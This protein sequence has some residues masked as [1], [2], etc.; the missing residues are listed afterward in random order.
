VFEEEWSGVR[1]HP[2]A[3]TAGALEAPAPTGLRQQRGRLALT[4][5]ENP[6]TAHS[7][8][9]GIYD[10]VLCGHSPFLLESCVWQ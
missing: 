9:V 3:A 6:S 10:V 5:F 8:L 4:T 2:I 7:L 1:L